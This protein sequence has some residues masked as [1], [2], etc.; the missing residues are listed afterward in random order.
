M[1]SFRDDRWLYT[2]SAVCFHL[3][4]SVRRTHKNSDSLARVISIVCCFM[5]RCTTLCPFK[6]LQCCAHIFQSLNV[7]LPLKLTCC[8]E[9]STHSCASVAR[10]RFSHEINLRRIFCS[11]AV[12][13][14]HRKKLTVMPHTVYII[15]VSRYRL[16]FA[17]T[18][19]HALR[20]CCKA[21]FRNVLLRFKSDR[22]CLPPKSS[23]SGLTLSNDNRQ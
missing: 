21:V 1:N 10:T 20:S 7:Y 12:T 5:S 6:E 9:T 13:N 22:C 15:L 19:G 11:L 4:R 8:L 23:P 2:T 16:P 18:A 3:Q 14:V 17:P